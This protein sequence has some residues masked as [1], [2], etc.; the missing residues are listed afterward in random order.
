M[1][2]T[3]VESVKMNKDVV[4]QGSTAHFTK[5]GWFLCVGVYLCLATWKPLEK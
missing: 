5:K 2:F 4:Q 1:L 3:Q